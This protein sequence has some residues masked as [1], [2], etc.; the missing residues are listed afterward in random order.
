[1]H[2]LFLVFILMFTVGC[3]T[4]PDVNQDISIH[5]AYKISNTNRIGMIY[6]KRGDVA[7]IKTEEGK[8]I[9]HRLEMDFSIGDQVIIIQD[10]NG[11]VFDFKIKH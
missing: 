10:A 8:K 4:K 9:S 7:Y 6:D 5:K 11:H 3:V 1:M 2:Y